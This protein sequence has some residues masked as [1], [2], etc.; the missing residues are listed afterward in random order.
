MFVK[1]LLATITYVE[2]TVDPKFFK[3]IIGKSGANSKLLSNI[4]SN[5]KI[6]HLKN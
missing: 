6:Q 3:H 2:L 1:K 5:N 4:N